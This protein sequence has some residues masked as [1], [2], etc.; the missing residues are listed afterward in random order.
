MFGSI[1][2]S[3]FF[4]DHLKSH[5]S[6]P[7]THHFFCSISIIFQH[8]DS[9]FFHKSLFVG[10]GCRVSRL[11]Y[12]CDLVPPPKMECEPHMG[13]EKHSLS[14]EDLDVMQPLLR[15]FKGAV[16]FLLVELCWINQHV[17][18]IAINWLVLWNLFDSAMIL[19]ERIN[20][21]VTR[22]GWSHRLGFDNIYIYIYIHTNSFIHSFHCITMHYNIALNYIASHRIN[23][24]TYIRNWCDVMWCGL[25]WY[26]MG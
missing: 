3:S 19:W 16:E 9:P 14:V 13:H 24:I 1:F 25:M 6:V 22:V 18:E 23:Y 8:V 10:T 21:S 2:W 11:G 12:V 4:W 15:D 20:Q 26:D 7:K 5:F 17:G